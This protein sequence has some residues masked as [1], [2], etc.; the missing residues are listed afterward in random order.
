MTRNTITEFE[1]LTDLLD[2]TGAIET[3]LW[4]ELTDGNY[5]HSVEDIAR[6]LESASCANGSWN[7]MIYTRDIESR[8]ADPQWCHDIDEALA[9]YRDNTGEN[10]DLS[11]LSEIVTFAVD[12]VA[13]GLSSRL[14]SLNRV[15][16]VTA[17]A[18]SLDAWPDV[19]AFG[20]ASEAEDFVACEIENRVQYLIDHSPHPVTEDERDQWAETEATLFI[21]TEERL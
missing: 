10:P 12:W 1:H 13:H 19:L 4:D 20:C 16:V 17:A 9:D 8:L 6:Q 15:A 5:W 21:I 3:Y 18:D 11:S 2:P 14:R 7:S